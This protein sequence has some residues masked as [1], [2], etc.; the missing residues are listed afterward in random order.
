MAYAKFSRIA[1]KGLYGK[2]VY[3]SDGTGTVQWT[4]YS[5]PNSTYS[6]SLDPNVTISANGKEDKPITTEAQTACCCRR[7]WQ[8]PNLK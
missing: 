6:L 8:M 4:D 2:A 5:E 3:Q 7:I 1:L